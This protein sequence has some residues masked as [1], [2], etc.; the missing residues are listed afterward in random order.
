M[1]IKLGICGVGRFAPYFIPL[2]KAHPAVDEVTLCDLDGAKLQERADHFQIARTCPSLDELCQ[3][4]VDA[5]AIFTQNTLHGPQAVQA[6]RA[7]KHVYSAVPSA[8]T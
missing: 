3:S 2:F 6:L 7:G 4:D 5:I 8:I 1:G